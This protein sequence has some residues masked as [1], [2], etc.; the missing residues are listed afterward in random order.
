MDIIKKLEHV[1]TI[2]G[3]I[4]FKHASKS[5]DDDRERRFIT[6][7]A[8]VEVVDTQ[9]DLV[10]VESLAKSMEIY[11][12]RGGPL[13][14]EHSN[15][16]VG[17]LVSHEIVT[18]EGGVKALKCDY[19]IFNHYPFDD[20]VWKSIVE[21]KFTGLSIA[22]MM[23]G[24]RTC[25]D[26]TCF[27]HVH[28]VDLLE[29]SLVR[30]PANKKSRILSHDNVISSSNADSDDLVVTPSTELPVTASVKSE[31][32]PRS[33]NSEVKVDMSDPAVVEKK[34]EN[35]EDCPKEKT[36]E[37]VE[38]V[39]LGLIVKSLENI[40]STLAKIN[41]RVEKL[42]QKSEDKSNEEKTVSVEPEV[43]TKSEPEPQPVTIS[44]EVIKTVVSEVIEE[45]LATKKQEE[46]KEEEVIVNT[47]SPSLTTKSA[48]NPQFIDLVPIPGTS[49]FVSRPGNW[50][51]VKKSLPPYVLTRD[52]LI[53]LASKNDWETL[54]ACALMMMKDLESENITII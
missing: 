54:E 17:R 27:N 33:S 18:T 26:Q 39:D 3:S 30:S 14:V 11:K 1:F 41:E 6:A 28:H 22:G 49:V 13:L 50:D 42:E 21:G 40:S 9:G 34:D 19:E 36:E 47:P 37:K 32:T 25:N 7:L 38:P 12:K 24:K 51:V 48:S 53:E 16:P 20:H 44:P 35:C 43:T 5:D 46:E 10:D 45:K 8:S 4:I 2:T 23:K 31:E 15:L 29:V 52:R